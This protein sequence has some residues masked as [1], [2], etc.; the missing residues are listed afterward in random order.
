MKRALFVLVSAAA[1]A[2]IWFGVLSH[3]VPSGQPPLGVM[4]LT[5]LRTDFNHAADRPRLILLLSPT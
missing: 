5:A 4:D 3:K 2:A 1:A